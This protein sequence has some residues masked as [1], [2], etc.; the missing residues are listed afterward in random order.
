MLNP[1]AITLR[2]LY[3]SFDKATHEWTDGV[4]ACHM[5]EASLDAATDRKWFILDGPVDAVWVENLNTVLDD[6]KK[7]ACVAARSSCA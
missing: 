1:K 7:C 4:L 6:N 3:G 5:R 2:Q